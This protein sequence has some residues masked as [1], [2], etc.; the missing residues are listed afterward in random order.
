[1]RTMDSD[2]FEGLVDRLNR[3]SVERHYDAYTDVGWDTEDLKVDP[4]DP[5]WELWPEDP[6]AATEWYRT[7][8]PE[9]RVRV[10]LHRVASAMRTGADFENILSRGLLS[11][12]FRLPGG[13]P[14]FRYLQHEVAEEAHHTMMFYEF[15]TRSGV[16]TNGLP[17]PL[18]RLAE[19]FVIPLNRIFPELFFLFVLGGEDPID[20]AQRQR[21]RAG[22]EH[23]LVERIMRIHVTEEARHRSFARHYLS[24]EAPNLGP[25]RRRILAAIAPLLLGVMARQMLLPDR[26]LAR[27]HHI[28]RRALRQAARSPQARQ[29]L[30]DSVSSVRRLC[31]ELGLVTPLGRV[32]WRLMGIAG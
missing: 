8:P 7:A 32:L 14:E 30:A 28:P 21:L 11:Y 13:R 26:E 23:P 4:D 10:G 3:Q 31:T 1:M 9:L 6:L 18:K 29:L 12:A 20:Y 2:A 27:T 17:R 24:S 19:W 15:V 16:R 25:V 5:R 22:E